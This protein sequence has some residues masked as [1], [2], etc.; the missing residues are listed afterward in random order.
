LKRKARALQKATFLQL[1]KL[2][3][4]LGIHIL[5]VHYYSPVPNILELEKTKAIWAGKSELPGLAVDLDEQVSNLRAICLPYQK[6]YVG[7]RIYREGAKEFRY[8]FGYIEAEALHAVIRH[9]RPR[10]VVEVGSGLSTYCMLAALRMNQEEGSGSSSMTSIEPHPSES[11]RGLAGTKLISRPVQSVPLKMFG[12]LGS[13]DLLFIDSSHTVKPAG[14]V[15]HLILEVLPRLRSGVIVHFH[16]INLPYDYQR[17]LLVNFLHWT[18]SSL[19]RAFLVFNHRVK[20][21]FC[22]SHLH[23]ERKDV[24]REVFPD[25][26]SQSDAEGLRADQYKPFEDISEHFPSS[27]YLQM[28]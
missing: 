18:E 15:N 11:L 16:D 5:P 17:D 14:D 10:K 1:H 3:I 21:I 19:L 12:E 27:L 26:N 2:A 8:A 20:I 13:N 9:Y 25:Y 6:E 7:N 23:Y 4:R 24:L 28:Q 22:F